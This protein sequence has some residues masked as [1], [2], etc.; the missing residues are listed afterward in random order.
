LSASS[1]SDAMGFEVFT[2]S[3]LADPFSLGDPVRLA[4]AGHAT[5]LRTSHP[6]WDDPPFIKDLLRQ[7]RLL[8]M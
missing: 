3:F 6:A 1:D 8:P 7:G 5:T 2:P 4:E